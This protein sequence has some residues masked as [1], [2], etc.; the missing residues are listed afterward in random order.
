MRHPQKQLVPTIY[1]DTRLPFPAEVSLTNLE[2]ARMQN[3]GE[4]VGGSTVS[5]CTLFF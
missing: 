3:Q 2:G 4:A 5:E 1:A